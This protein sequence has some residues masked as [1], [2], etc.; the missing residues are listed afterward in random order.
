MLQR[1][2]VSLQFFLNSSFFFFA[3]LWKLSTHLLVSHMST[4]GGEG[5]GEGDMDAAGAAGPDPGDAFP[6]P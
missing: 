6:D 3:H 4:H 1:L 2:Q 5:G